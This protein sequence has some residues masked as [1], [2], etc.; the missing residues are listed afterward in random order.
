MERTW[1]HGCLDLFIAGGVLIYGKRDG[2]KP[3][4]GG[5]VKSTGLD[6]LFN[7]EGALY[8]LRM[9]VFAVHYWLAS[10]F[11]VG[12]RLQSSGTVL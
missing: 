7:V 5:N 9:T 3:G 1:E 2:E 8:S 6:I 4:A 11:F 10:V 12:V